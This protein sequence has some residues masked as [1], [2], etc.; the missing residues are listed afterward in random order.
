MKAVRISAVI[1][2]NNEEGSVGDVVRVC[3]N[4]CDEVIVVDDGSSDSTFAKS[5][6]AGAIV[7]RNNSRMGIVASTAL[8]LEMAQGEILVTLDGDGQHDPAE[9]PT[10]IQPI[11]DGSAD[12]V[13]GRRTC[14][15][16]VSE[17]I[18]AKLVNLRVECVD[19]G[20]GY[21]A[22]RRNM[23]RKMH[24]WGACL[25]GSFVLEAY[26]HGAR[27]TE[28]PISI[29]ERRNGESHWPSS[30]SRGMPHGKQ[31][32]MLLPRIIKPQG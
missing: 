25:C 31:L 10:I 28:V 4:Y 12:L 15:L 11:V 1:P 7:H 6:E 2:A 3:R 17:K 20:T 29:H 9:I 30:F 22:M 16:P 32:V 19:V 26:R 8:G 24:L 5:K 27:V 13:M 14:K 23:A 18:I 21:R